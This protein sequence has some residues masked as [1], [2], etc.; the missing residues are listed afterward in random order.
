MN[1][2]DKLNLISTG[3]K[4][5]D[6][7]IDI[8]EDLSVLLDDKNIIDKFEPY[9]VSFELIHYLRSKAYDNEKEYTSKRQYPIFCLYD[10]SYDLDKLDISS[11][12]KL[13]QYFNALKDKVKHDY[14]LK[15]RIMDDNW[16]QFE[17]D[18][19]GRRYM[20]KICFENNNTC[21]IREWIIYNN[22]K[23]LESLRREGFEA[24]LNDDG[25]LKIKW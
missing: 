13:K 10:R 4:T 2:K 16:L 22:D 5:E 21:A 11:I 9:S 7:I 15:K 8:I 23:S 17:F 12:N 25:T 14:N 19:L 18:Y 20:L 1:L 3:G 6:D 24:N